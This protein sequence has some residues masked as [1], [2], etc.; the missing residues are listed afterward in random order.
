[1]LIHQRAARIAGLDRHADLEISHIILCA[2][3]RR[4]V[5]LGKLGRKPLQTDVSS[6][7]SL[8]ESIFTAL[9]AMKP[10]LVT[11]RTGARCCQR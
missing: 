1:M 7:K 11:K 10:A 4:D 8:A 2:G 5:A 6:A 3:E 9:A